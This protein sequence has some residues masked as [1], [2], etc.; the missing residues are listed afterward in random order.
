MRVFQNFIVEANVKVTLI[1]ILFA[2]VSAAQSASIE[3]RVTDP[4]GATVPRATVVITA[5]DANIHRTTFSDNSGAYRFAAVTPGEYLMTAKADGFTGSPALP[6]MAVAAT[7]AK[8]DVQLTLASLNSQVQVTASGTAQ[9]TDEESKVIDIID[10]RQ[11]LERA[12]FS[13]TQAVRL[14]PGLRVEQTGG[15]GAFT[16]IQARGMRAYDTALLIDGFRLRD[17]ASPQGD[18]TGFFGDLMLADTDRIEIERGSG[19]SLYGTNATAAVINVVTDQGGGPFHGSFDAE[20]GGL[21]LFRSAA[22]GA[23]GAWKDRLRYTTGVSH[24]NV[25]RGIDGND[26]YRNTSAQGF[27]QLALYPGAMLT[28]RIY[29]SDAY[30]DLNSSPY[31]VAASRLPN[32]EFVTAIANV[33]FIPSPDDPDSRRSARYFSGLFG[34][35][36]QITPGV[37]YRINYQGL[38]TRRDNRDGPGGTRFP[39]PFSTSNLFEGR[40]DTVQARTDLQT[41]RYNLLTAGYEW[42]RENF[43]NR[44]TDENPVIARRVNARLEIIQKSHSAFVQDQVR[45]LN[46][47][48]Q[49]SVSGRTQGFDLSTPVFAGANALYQSL[50]LSAPKRA[51]TGDAS[52][53][54][55]LRPS[56]TKLRAHAGN[57]YRVPSL[58]ERFGSSFYF[59]SFSPY[60]DPFLRPERLLAFDAGIDQYLAGNRVRV[61][62][63]FFYTRIQEAIVFDSS[64]AINNYGRFGGYTNARGG[65]ARG[66]E[67]SVDATPARG[68]SLNTS[69]TYTNADERQSTLLGGSLRSIRVFPHMFTALL[70]QRIG[71]RIDVTFDFL[72]ASD[73]IFPFFAGSGSR[74][75]LFP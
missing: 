14:V 59:G 11:L 27:A 47:R 17:A 24:L 31:A 73:Y 33:T 13:L 32:T 54:Y 23:G 22:K 35:T 55:F 8:A 69:Y 58:Y 34:F 18:A 56:G 12:H 4:S 25:M 21:G 49:F 67:L 29:A 72:A 62:G 2:A 30:S 48:L 20:G 53:A 60:G 38:S 46:N 71:K 52:M 65:L 64:S 66:L 39:P 16:R 70:T 19:S 50:Q 63:T 28:A 61:R 51:W 45:L 75:F 6:V 40:L 41:G 5:R 7:A 36:Q 26:R 57:G 9:S 68:L 15:P 3:G 1:H 44:S 37:S 42:E 74:P 43:D 10:S